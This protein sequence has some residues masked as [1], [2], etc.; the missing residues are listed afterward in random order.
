M[1]L[2]TRMTLGALAAALACSAAQAQLKPSGPGTPPL[3]PTS[4]EEKK[5]D[6]QAAKEDAATTAA[7]HWLA[8]I[9]AGDSGKA[10]DACAS[11]FKQRVKRD[12]FIQSLPSARGP[13]GATKQR[14]REV[15]SYST[16]LAGAPDGEYVTVRFNTQF[17]KKSD[18]QELLTMIY[19]EGAWRPTGYFIR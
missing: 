10:W 15:A 7:Q 2:T 6:A 11:L 5:T 12:D 1:K 3:P 4:V 16:K 9:D 19:E 14:K 8:L 13:F 17:E 18:A